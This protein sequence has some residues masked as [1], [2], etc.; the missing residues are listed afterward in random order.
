MHIFYSPGNHEKCIHLD[1][2]ESGHCIR[3]LRLKTGDRVGVIN[4][5]GVFYTSRILKPDPENTLLE[6][7][8]EIK[9]YGKRNYSLHIAI[10]PTKNMERFEWFIEKSVEIGID[11]ITPVYCQ[12]SERTKL[13]VDRLRRVI[14]SAVKQSRNAYLPK[15]NM[16]AT[17][18]DIAGKDTDAEK[19]IAHCSD[20]PK[21]HLVSIPVK[22]K[23][24]L[25]LI[26]PEGDFSEPE[27]VKAS[28]NGFVPVSLGP[29]RLRTETAGVV[30]AQIIS[31]RNIIAELK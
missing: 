24:V 13:R 23:N 10:A 30:A 4:G 8:S 14:L 7:V 5:E 1:P 17:F 6:I 3:V 22:H 12:R 15:L 31:D 27:L 28:A 20:E 9:N 16:P 25:I 18:D 21:D 19:Y 26:G 2:S 11:E 29:G